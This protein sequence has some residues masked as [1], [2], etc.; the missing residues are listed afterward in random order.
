MLS[1][2]NEATTTEETKQELIAKGYEVVDLNDAANNVY[3]KGAHWKLSLHGVKLSTHWQEADAWSEAFE[4]NEG[5]FARSYTMDELLDAMLAYKHPSALS[6]DCNAYAWNERVVQ[7][8]TFVYSANLGITIR[9]MGEPA[10]KSFRA[11][12]EGNS[13][14][15]R[16]RAL[17][18][19]YEQFSEWIGTEVPKV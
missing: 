14:G 2:P 15:Q 11:V 12:A 10:W 3:V 9:I 6:G 1:V 18:E 16:H 13:D 7:G 5:T 17:T 8:Q 4:R 19:L